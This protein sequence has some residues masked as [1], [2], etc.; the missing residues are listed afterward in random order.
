[1]DQRNEQQRSK[2]EQRK[3]IKRAQQPNA[4]VQQDFEQAPPVIDGKDR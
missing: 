1:M 3:A 4:H 2:A